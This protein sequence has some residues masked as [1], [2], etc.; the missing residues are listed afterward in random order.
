MEKLDKNAIKL[1]EELCEKEVERTGL[2]LIYDEEETSEIKTNGG[3][4]I[5]FHQKMSFDLEGMGKV[6]IR[7]Q[8]DL[9]F[10]DGKWKARNPDRFYGYTLSIMVNDFPITPYISLYDFISKEELLEKLSSK[11]F[12][13][14]LDRHM[15]LKEE[16][17]D[18][19]EDA[20]IF[21]NKRKM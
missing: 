11:E 18:I 13:T 2:P 8:R 16:I 12:K 19:R 14:M 17:E 7:N 15:K 21:I 5:Y 1:I 10:E 4:A 3:K 6:V 9:H 20:N